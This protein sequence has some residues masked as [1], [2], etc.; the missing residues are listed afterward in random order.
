VVYGDFVVV[1][2]TAEELAVVG[3]EVVEAFWYG[4]GL[5]FEIFRDLLDV[6]LGLLNVLGLSLDADLRALWASVGLSRDV[7]LDAKLLLELAAG[8]TSPSDEKAVLLWLD[9]DVLGDLRLLVLDESFDRSADLVHN[10]LVSLHANSVALDIS[11]W[12][13][14]HAVVKALVLWSTSLQ[15][16]VAEIGSCY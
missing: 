12:E 14:D 2:E 9:F 10:R 5:A 3:D 13:A 6:S 15:D 4:D 7:D 1:A 11:L 8:L 16:D